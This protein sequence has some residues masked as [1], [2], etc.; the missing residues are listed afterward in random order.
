MTTYSLDT[1]SFIEHAQGKDHPTQGTPKGMT[2][3]PWVWPKKRVQPPWVHLLFDVLDP[4][5]LTPFRCIKVLHG[6]TIFLSNI[7]IDLRNIY[8]SLN[9]IRVKLHLD[10]HFSQKKDSWA[11][12]TPRDLKKV[13]SQ[14]SFFIA[15]IF[16]EY[17]SLEYFCIFS[18]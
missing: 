11:I 1:P 5:F 9:A 6:P 8:T 16:S 13:G 14:S 2:L 10:P 15:Y 3:L 18:F 7:N 12:N 17:L 4:N